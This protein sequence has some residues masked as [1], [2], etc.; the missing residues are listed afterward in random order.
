MDSNWKL[1]TIYGDLG[2]D[3]AADQYPQVNVCADCIA[4]DEKRKEDA[5]IVSINGPADPDFGDE[6][7][8]CGDCE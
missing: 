1:C 4:R 3:S 8:L 5:M 7:G 2:A 6:C